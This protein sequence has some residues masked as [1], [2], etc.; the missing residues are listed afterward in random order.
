MAAGS[1][2]LAFAELAFGG[3]LLTS[4]ITGESIGELLTK[5]LTEKGKQKLHSKQVERNAAVEEQI[6]NAVAPEELK[7]DIGLSNKS[8]N[9]AVSPQSSSD[10]FSRYEQQ[11]ETYLKRHLT[12]TEERELKQLVGEKQG[13]YKPPTTRITP[14][15]Q[16]H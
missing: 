14:T 13:T 5:G 1:Q 2:P 16:L 7:A 4:A 10:L 15:G 12:K 3:L 11:L 6:E 8:G 9:V